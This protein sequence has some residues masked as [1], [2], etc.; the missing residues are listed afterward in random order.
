MGAA[1]L[2]VIP[3][4]AASGGVSFGGG[5]ALTLTPDDCD[6]IN[7]K[8]QCPAVAAAA[9]LVQARTQVVY[10]NRN[11]VPDDVY[12]TT[13][14]YL[15]VREWPLEEG[16]SFTDRDVRN[17]NKVC[18]L[19]Q[20]IVKQL[21]PDEDPIG[22]EI[23]VQNVSFRVIGVLAAKGANMVGMDQ[24]DV[25]LAPWTT[26]KFRVTGLSAATANQ[27][28]NNG[29]TS[30]QVN[31]LSDRYPGTSGG[32]YPVASAAQQA[33]TPQP[34]RFINVN[35]IIASA[36]KPSDIPR[37]IQEITAVLRARHHIRAGEPDDFNIRDMT[38]MTSAL[39]STAGV[40][41]NLLLAV[42]FI[43]L[44]VGGVGIMNIMLVSVTERTREIG[45]RM[46]VGARS[47]DV[48]RQF[49]FEAVF[50]CLIGGII[51]IIVG[52]LGSYLVNVF[53]HWPTVL[54]VEAIAAAVGVSV[55]V[56]VVFG[57]YP[58]WK[59]SRLDPIE[60]LRYE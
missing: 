51:G 43:S 54:S 36:G 24:D 60:A 44:V 18:I 17:A 10:E 29:A 42:A 6:A 46:A 32:L 48:L 41:Q 2:M 30:G 37:A 20:T 40:M 59:G 53:L 9:P 28:A 7:D 31:T 58:A 13:S 22:K 16:Q 19:G 14:D 23:R 38:E 5:S 1:N 33:D 39:T 47:R 35:R 12:G 8:N 50:L 11:W 55:V 27:S 49:L 45:L 3:G 52:K 56:G 34:V 15:K 25:L 26:I 4:Q 57:Y 21:F